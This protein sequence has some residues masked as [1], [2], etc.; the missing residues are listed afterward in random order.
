MAKVRTITQTH[1]EI[2]GIALLNLWG[3]GQGTIEMDA[4]R[5]PFGELS[6]KNFL[7]AINDGGFGCESIDSAE[8]DRTINVS[9]ETLEKHEGE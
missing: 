1:R 8:H 5:I 4:V 3:G 6:L 7:S 9:G 2:S